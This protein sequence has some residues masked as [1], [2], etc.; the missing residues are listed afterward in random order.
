MSN[1]KWMS[2]ALALLLALALMVG[3]LPVMTGSEDGQMEAFA[4]AVQE[5]VETVNREVGEQLPD[6]LR[7]QKDKAVAYLRINIGETAN[8]YEASGNYLVDG[9]DVITSFG[10]Q[11]RV[12]EGSISIRKTSLIMQFSPQ[13]EP[14]L[15]LPLTMAH[16]VKDGVLNVDSDNIKIQN[17]K[18]D[19]A[20]VDGRTVYNVRAEDM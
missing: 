10:S 6:V 1:K 20:E 16:E 9:E 2:N 12:G 13:D 14:I 15:C 4:R 18:V 7:A 5:E 8:S 3:A 11:Y 17:V 19:T